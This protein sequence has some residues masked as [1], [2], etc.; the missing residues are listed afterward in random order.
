VG[1]CKSN[2]KYNVFSFRADD[3]L[4]AA[5]RK[6]AEP[7]PSIGDF[8]AEAAEVKAMNETVRVQVFDQLPVN[9]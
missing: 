3:E 8:L 4:A 7:Y 2:P 1:R 5:I 9:R 6:A